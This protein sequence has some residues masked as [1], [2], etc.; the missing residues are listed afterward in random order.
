MFLTQWKKP[1]TSGNLEI[2]KNKKCLLVANIPVTNNE[3]LTKIIKTLGSKLNC[4]ITEQDI[5]AA[6]RIKSVNAPNHFWLWSNSINWLTARK[7]IM[8]K[9][10]AT[11]SSNLSQKSHISINEVVSKSQQNLF[12][13]ARKAK[14]ALGW[15][16]AC[17]DFPRIG[18]YEKVKVRW[19]SEINVWGRSANTGSSAKTAAA[20]QF[21][22][23]GNT[24]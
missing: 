14:S 5:E 9:S 24:I 6:F 11:T 16:Y 8:E 3:N 18:I 21:N 10:I 22:T 20:R 4:L 1:D 2:E 13:K 19:V 12:Y 15:K 7:M 17:L 23:Q